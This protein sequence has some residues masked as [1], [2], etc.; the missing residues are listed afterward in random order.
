MS[1]PGFPSVTP[2]IFLHGEKKVD[3]NILLY[4]ALPSSFHS[5]SIHLMA[6]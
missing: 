4:L 1:L 3:F 2:F 5:S 6:R